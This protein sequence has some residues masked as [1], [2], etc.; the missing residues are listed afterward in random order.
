MT[1]RMVYKWYT[2]VYNGS[3]VIGLIGYII[4]LSVFFGVAALF[5]AGPGFI[6]VGIMFLSYGLYFG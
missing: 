6:Q 3:F 2:V 4:I 5:N 1:P